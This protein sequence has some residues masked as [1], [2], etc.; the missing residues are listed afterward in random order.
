MKTLNRTQEDNLKITVTAST[1]DGPHRTNETNNTSAPKPIPGNS[2][3]LKSLLDDLEDKIDGN[4]QNYKRLSRGKLGVTQDPQKV[5][6][7]NNDAK[8]QPIGISGVSAMKAVNTVT[9]DTKGDQGFKI[10][11]KFTSKTANK[12]QATD[13]SSSKNLTDS[14]SYTNLRGN[15]VVVLK[16][17][18]K[19]KTI[20]EQT[21]FRDLTTSKQLDRSGDL[22]L[23]RSGS[24][25][26]KYK[27]ANPTRDDN[28]SGKRPQGSVALNSKNVPELGNSKMLS[29]SHEE[30]FDFDDVAKLKKNADTRGSQRKNGSFRSNGSNKDIP[31]L[32][33]SQIMKFQEEKFKYNTKR[34]KDQKTYGR[35]PNGA[36][37]EDNFDEEFDKFQAER[38]NNKKRNTT[39][40]ALTETERQN[41][42][43]QRKLTFATSPSAYNPSAFKKTSNP[44]QYRKESEPTY[45]YTFKPYAHTFA[46]DYSKKGL[47]EEINEEGDNDSNKT[48]KRSLNNSTRDLNQL[49]DFYHFNPENR[50]YTESFYEKKGMMAL[51][52]GPATE[53]IASLKKMI[54]D[55]RNANAQLVGQNSQL[56]TDLFFAKNKEKGLE[57]KNEYQNKKL[58]KLIHEKNHINSTNNR[59]QFYENKLAQI[60]I[61]LGNANSYEEGSVI[62]RIIQRNIEHSGVNKSEVDYLI[63]FKSRVEIIEHSKPITV[64]EASQTIPNKF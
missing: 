59:H 38:E 53:D 19:A 36:L 13:V 35:K 17:E 11:A 51:N 33:N 37:N 5:L 16:S 49:K 24:E 55:L 50:N 21:R 58:N 61:R 15:K 63:D 44:D 43:D 8:N 47:P 9:Y 7:S 40:K 52:Q 46:G 2:D 10:T 26:K 41:E 6:S 48:I 23:S 60:E 25:D 28:K 12:T 27:R 57:K 31:I 56:N 39:G 14:S 54:E 4:L 64:L 3:V 32:S 30:T 20:E 22:L 29:K 42:G 18:Y 62:H 34:A 45:T 1:N